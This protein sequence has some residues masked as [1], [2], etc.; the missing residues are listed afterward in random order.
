MRIVME[1]PS[2]SK[3]CGGI[4]DN[5][6]LAESFIP[7]MMLRFQHISNGYPIVDTEW[8]VGLPDYTFP[9]CDIC[10]TYSDTPYLDKL[11]NLPQIGKVYILML[12]YGMNLPVE[13]RNIH[14]KKVTVLCSSKKLEDLILKEGVKVHRL[15]LGL[16]MSS[17]FDD[18]IHREKYLA[19]LFHDMLT[20]KYTTAVT[21]ADNLFNDGIING[22]IVFGKSNNFNK[23]KSPRGLRIFYPNATPEQIKTIFNTCSCFLMPSISEGLNL[24]PLESALCGCPPVLCDGAIGE[25]FIDRENCFIVPRENKQQMYA[26]CADVVTNFDKYSQ[27]FMYKTQ[28]L[29]QDMSWSNVIKKLT[30]IIC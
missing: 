11:V 27:P 4:R 14:N 2:F 24:T 20:K 16:N 12:S 8:S 1:L 28:E 23:Y 7:K 10:V 21:V 13:R 18:N 6:L 15:G 25:V 5:V 29:T 26:R 22:V 19:I 9:E 17:F 3:T 30:D